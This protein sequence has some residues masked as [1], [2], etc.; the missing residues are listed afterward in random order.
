VFG[1][2]VDGRWKKGFLARH[3]GNVGDYAGLFAGYE[4]GDC[5]L[6]HADGMGEVYIQQRVS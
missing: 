1:C 2:D 6:G 4:M 5:E 3:A